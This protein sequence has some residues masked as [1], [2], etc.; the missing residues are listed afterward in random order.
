MP[1]EHH[2]GLRAR[3]RGRAALH[4]DGAARRDRPQARPHRPEDE[5]RREARRDGADLRGPGLRSRATRSSTG[6]SSRPTSTSSRAARS[7]S[8]TS[9][10][11]ASSGSEMTTT[12]MVMGT[13]HYMS[14]EQVRG[15]KADARS[16]VF[17]LGCV[18]YEMLTGRKPFDAESMHAVLYKIMQEEPVPLREA[19]PGTPGDPRAGRRAVAREEPGRALRERGRDAGRD[20]PGPSG[21][22]GGEGTT[23]AS[24][25]SNGRRPAR[26]RERRCAPPRVSAA[27]PPRCPAAPCRPRP[28]REAGGRS[29]SA[30]G[31]PSRRCWA[32]AGHCGSTCSAGRPSRAPRPPG[33]ARSRSGRS[34]RRSSSL[35]GSS[36]P[37]SC[38]DAVRQAEG[39]LKLDARNVAARQVL[40]EAAATLQRID[41][42]VGRDPRGRRG[43]RTPRGRGPRPD[44]ARPRPPRSGEGRHR[45]RKRVP[46]A[47]PRRPAGSQQQARRAAEQA[48]AE[49]APAFAEGVEL[50][51]QGDGALAAGQAPSAARRFLEARRQFE[52][53][54][55]VSR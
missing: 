43:P 22:G 49:S 32:E 27:T 50:E 44:D 30:S 36:K 51:R 42:A 18:L 15:A 19:A 35:A 12:G 9:G 17:A 47:G 48:G 5:P 28:R 23:S 20:P 52:R 6:T 2:H 45:R 37:A 14:P 54:R 29:S 13:P 3:P 31:S 21:G 24:R 8:W 46:P 11:P 55:R 26:S 34:T 40:D 10:W 1:P 16:D 7:R 4:G 33:S 39:A 38:A 25:A 53:A 41:E